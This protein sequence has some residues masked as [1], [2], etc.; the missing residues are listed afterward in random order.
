MPAKGGQA[1]LTDDELKRA[2]AHM[3]NES[4]GNFE[5]P[6]AGASDAAAS[7]AAASGSVGDTSA[8]AASD[9]PAATASADGQKVFETACAACH[10]ATSAIPNSPKITKNDEWAPR[11]KQ[12]KET[13][14]KHAIEGFTGPGGS[15]MPAKGGNAGLSDDEVKAA[16][17]YMVNQSGGKI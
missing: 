7:D 13:L 15:L 6:A 10:G 3:T 4:G 12:G 8:A 1:D 9:S 14:F 2:I 17:T 5:V 16:V 11:I